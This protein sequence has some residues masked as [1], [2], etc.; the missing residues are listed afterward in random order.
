M[1]RTPRSDRSRRAARDAGRARLAADR[2]IRLVIA[3][4]EPLH[5]DAPGSDDLDRVG[6]GV[7]SLVLLRS[8]PPHGPGPRPVRREREHGYIAW[9][10]GAAETFGEE[11]WI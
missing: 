9:A 2:Q 3:D 4:E 6:H 1:P 11:M 10:R 8:E 7:P 5:Q